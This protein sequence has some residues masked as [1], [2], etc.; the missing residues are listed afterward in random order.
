MPKVSIVI[1]AYNQARY[2]AQA[3]E[4]CLAQTH[5]DLEVVVVDDGSTDE[6]PAVV[7]R[8]AN[9]IRCVR[10]AN[11]GLPAARNRGFRESTGGYVCFLDA[12]DW[13]HPE[14]IRKQAEVLDAD[15]AAGFV[16]CDIETVDEGGRP[17]AKQPSVGAVGAELSGNILPVLIKAGYFPPHTVMMRRRVLEELGGFDPELGGHADYDL[18]LRAA[19]AGHRA[20]YLDE[21]LASY[22]THAGSM[23]RD[24]RHM[25]ETR[26]AALTKLARSHPDLAGRGLHQ[27]QQSNQD[28]FQANEWLQANW[29][30]VLSQGG[31]MA[32]TGAEGGERFSFLK[33]LARARL[34]TGREEQ[35]AVWEV[36]LGGAQSHALLLQPPAEFVFEV[37]T[38]ARGRFTTAI[39]LHPDVWA[40]PQAG[41]CEF[42]VRIDSRAAL[43]LAID[44]T[45]LASDRG[46]HP[47]TLDV[48]ESAAGRHEVVLETRGIEG[49][50][51]RWAL[52]RAPLF[53]WQP[54]AEP[55]PR[56][57]TPATA[58]IQSP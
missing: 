14:K 4:S 17:V 52:W 49:N 57:T 39:A 35:K 1:P 40:N 47:V 19:A 21:R 51:F 48:P 2:L 29:E 36:T 46:W 9:R 43:A 3:I 41:P 33:N 32:S 31:G 27:L 50:D 22:R 58:T 30:K 15:A 5:S 7:A 37:P 55:P 20:V 23:S 11:A 53:T 54:A 42:G 10:Q 13:F 26:Q 45:R 8:F 38:G 6:T 56:Q 24:G 28:L 16:Y 12:D 18:W 25:G 44:P 34:R